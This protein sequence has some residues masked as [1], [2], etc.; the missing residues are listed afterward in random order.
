MVRYCRAGEVC[1]FRN[2]STQSVHA[3]EQLL[4]NMY[5]CKVTICKENR[6]ERAQ[7]WGEMP[8]VAQ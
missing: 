1:P 5:F 3:F 6:D 4:Y 7:K 8:R 2:I